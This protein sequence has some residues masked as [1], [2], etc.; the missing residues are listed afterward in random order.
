MSIL[1]YHRKQAR[2]GLIPIYLDKEPGGHI[3]KMTS[4]TTPSPYVVSTGG[5]VGW[6]GANEPAW[7]AFDRNNNTETR[8]YDWLYGAQTCWIRITLD[9]PMK[10]YKMFLKF[11]VRS[12]YQSQFNSIVL[13]LRYG[14][15]DVGYQSVNLGNPWPNITYYN[16][17]LNVLDIN[18]GLS[19]TPAES[20]YTFLFF[21]A[22]GGL[23]GY[24]EW[25]PA[26]NT[27]QLYEYYGNY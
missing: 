10:V 14:A 11:N 3:P 27:I 19:F 13:A 5:F 8:P 2:Y 24:T 17:D 7:W 16:Q 22:N 6:L 20:I 12:S 25:Y 4:Y 15:G 23:P 9:R 18:T 21:N 1:T 26:V